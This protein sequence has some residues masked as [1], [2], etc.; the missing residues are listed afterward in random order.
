MRHKINIK[1]ISVNKAYTGRRFKTPEHAEFKRQMLLLTPCICNVDIWPKMC[2]KIVF[3]FSNPKQDIDGALKQ[4]ID[5]LQD[6]YM[7][8][9]NQI[10]R[11]EVDKVIVPK[12]DEYIEFEF[13][14]Y[15]N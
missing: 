1:P 13:D 7:F 6:K 14:E 10:Y 12:G 11:L 2:L 3:G 8:N 5:A 9:D 15:F 4:T